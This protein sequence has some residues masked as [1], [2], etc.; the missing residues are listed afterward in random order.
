MSKRVKNE[1]WFIKNF[2]SD[3]HNDKII[4]PRFQRKKKWSV[5][6]SK[7]RTPNEK[8]YIEFLFKTENSVHPITFGKTGNIYSNID[9]NNRINAIEHFMRKPFEV[10]PDHLKELDIFINDIQNQEEKYKLDKE[11]KSKLKDIFRELSYNEII[12]FKYHKYFRNNGYED[13]YLKKLKQYRDD[14]EPVIEK[15]QNKLKLK[16]D[17]SFDEVVI[18]V[19]IFEEYTTDELCNIFESINKYSTRLTETE[20][21]SS[22]LFN[23][24]DF[25]I[26]D[27]VFKTE[28]DQHIKK[29]YEEKAEK[30][31][32]KCFEYNENKDEPSAFDFIVGFQN[33]CNEKYNLIR[34]SD[35]DGMSLYFK[36]YN[37][38][39]NGFI[40][41]FTTE[42]VNK[43]IDKVIYA[44]EILKELE[45]FIFTDNINE[46]L[47]NKQCREKIKTLKKNNMYIIISCIFGYHN[48]EID[49]SIIINNIEKCLIYHFIVGD[50]KNKEE[51]EYYRNSDSI[52]YRAG[53]SFIDS[54]AKKILFEPNEISN[55]ITRKSFNSLLDLLYSEANEPE[56]KKS[57]KQKRRRVLKFYEKT[58]MFYYY[59]Q[60]IPTNILKNKFSIEHICPYSCSWE[61]EIDMDRPGN[62]IPVIDTEN[63]GRGNGPISY[64][65][66]NNSPLYEYTKDII[67]DDEK[68]NN[69]IEYQDKSSPNIINNEL[70][71]SMCKDNEEIY[72]KKFIDNIFRL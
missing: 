41:T 19:N 9:G 13:L 11:E 71:N 10:F 72:K 2:M 24:T 59:K 58:L 49:K 69:I 7:N 31:V 1:Q 43:F 54:K 8:E 5:L 15:T 56:M 65:R 29:Y 67:P 48:D 26:N 16:N 3:L 39:Y 27:K 17:S 53:G 20:L 37:T 61:G 60:S 4:K 23:Y 45:N 47:F 68:Y 12:S 70:F 64:Y 22:S 33:L 62:L 32:L 51:K 28:L 55:K 36:L 18:N 21:L 50:L 6:P 25:R 35:T 30:E 42:N 57:G 63:S 52:S 38:L 40:D 46:K 44:C 66:M 14:F 34:K